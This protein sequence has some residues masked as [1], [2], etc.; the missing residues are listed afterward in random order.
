MTVSYIVN[1][2]HP[3]L[4]HVR[5]LLKT[6]QFR[7][8]PVRQVMGLTSRWPRPIN[9]D[10]CPPRLGYLTPPAR[11]ATQASLIRSACP[12]VNMFM[13]ESCV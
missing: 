3:F 9:P 5:D 8:V 11:N 13:Q 7:P 6:G 10:T 4:P 1:R 2:V 12:A